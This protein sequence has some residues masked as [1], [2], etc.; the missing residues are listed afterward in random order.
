M[1]QFEKINRNYGPNSLESRR[2]VETESLQA[3]CEGGND[4]PNECREL[5]NRF[6]HRL[7]LDNLRLTSVNWRADRLGYD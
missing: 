6:E 5:M 7:R 4:A 3:R 2:F 1:S